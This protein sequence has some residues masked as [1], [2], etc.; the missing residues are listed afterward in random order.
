MSVVQDFE[1]TLA[2]SGQ[3]TQLQVEGLHAQVRD[4]VARNKEL[5]TENMRL[6]RLLSQTVTC[7]SC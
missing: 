6:T 5:A 2:V 1:R 4:L 7:V 3:Q